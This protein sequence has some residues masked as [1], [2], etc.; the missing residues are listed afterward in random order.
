MRLEPRMLSSG[1][2]LYRQYLLTVHAME[3]YIDRLGGDVGNMIMDLQDSWS[4]DFNQKNQPRDI[5]ASA[6]RCDREGGWALSNG[7]A[8]FLVK[9]GEYYSVVI[10]T[11]SMKREAA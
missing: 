4:F 9:P 11:L 3:R 7:R 1:C 2:V 6:A 8:V 10:T 5:C